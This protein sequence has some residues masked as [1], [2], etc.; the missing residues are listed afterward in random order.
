MWIIGALALVAIGVAGIC[1]DLDRSAMPARPR[2]RL[3]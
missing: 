1:A 3:R 2:G